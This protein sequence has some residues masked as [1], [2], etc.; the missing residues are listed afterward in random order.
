MAGRADVYMLTSAPGLE[1]VA[2]DEAR[3]KL[4]ASPYALMRGKAFVAAKSGFDFLRLR[5]A[6]NVYRLLCVGEINTSRSA[7]EEI[8]IRDFDYKA[9][10][11]RGG[12]ARGFSVRAS[13]AGRHGRSRFEI[14]D[15]FGRALSKKTGMIFFDG[16][17]SERAD[18]NSNGIIESGERSRGAVS[19][20]ATKFAELRLDV[21]EGFYLLSQ[22]L[23]GAG[24]R[25]RGGKAF[26]KAAL[27]PTVAHSLVWLTNPRGCDVFFDPFCGSG[28]LLCER[29]EY[30]RAGLFG[31]DI[32]Y[33]AIEA[34]R[35]NLVGAGAGET[36]LFNGD[37][38]DI[39]IE[40]G[41]VSSVVTNPPWGNQIH[42]D[43]IGGLYRDLMSR[44]KVWLGGDG[45]AVVL[46]PGGAP[47]A[48]A[49]QGS[50]MH[51]ETLREVSLHGTLARVHSLAPG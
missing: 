31:A 32:N 18:Q 13:V 42:A 14:A 24:F 34:A 6:D 12:M 50:G 20:E 28:T 48:E 8:N 25:F 45:R 3:V 30:P 37:I 43:E 19:D 5:S 40:A 26:S 38:R 46:A 17:E 35:I 27:R 11:T 7:Q 9:C 1:D 41:S 22:K 36:K 47:V 21:V 29:A 2:M 15:A 33:A 49:A 51:C 39:K 23:T 44:L 4:G 10:F 16:P